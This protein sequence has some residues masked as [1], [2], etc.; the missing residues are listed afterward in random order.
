MFFLGIDI[1][2]TN[3]KAVLLDPDGRICNRMSIPFQWETDRGNESA[4]RYKHFSGI[5]EYFASKGHPVGTE[6]ACSVSAQGGSFL[7]LDNRCRPL[8]EVHWTEPASENTVRSMISRLD[9]LSYY[10]VTGWSPDGLLAAFKL[11]EIVAA[12]QMPKDTRFFATVPDFLYSQL[13][14]ETAVDI[15]NAQISGMCDFRKGRWHE[16]IVKWTG[17]D[18]HILPEIVEKPEVLFEKVSNPWGKI[19]FVTASHDQYAAMEAAG[20]V[21]DKDVMLG[22]GTVWVIN[23]RT[24]GPVYDDTHF[25][26]H[27]G[28][29]LSG[30]CFG[31]IIAVDRIGRGFDKL[32]NRLGVGEEEL[33]SGEATFPKEDIPAGPVTVDIAEGI[34]EP[35]L[36]NALALRRYMEWAASRV[37]FILDQFSLKTN[38]SRLVM[39]G[40]A[41]VSSFW[42]RV[43][44]DICDIP[45]EAIAFPEFTAYGAALLARKA[46]TGETHPG[47]RPGEIKST[48]HKP[49]PESQYRCWYRSYQYPMLA[50]CYR[51]VSP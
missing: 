4:V 2:S 6:A 12:G 47:R 5:L 43:I 1:G 39:T 15:S 26:T 19:S 7:L 50:G 28:R 44:A 3:T 21:E 32:R 24:T 13:T 31:N 45:V 14:G 29:D 18:E 22:T 25:M 42:P 37:A 33:A 48:L 30:E 40:G 41:A 20:L 51:Q 36:N 38:L 9:K 49:R 11:K 23:R 16:D 46:V 8:R 34:V 17:I 27:P 35:E 10:H